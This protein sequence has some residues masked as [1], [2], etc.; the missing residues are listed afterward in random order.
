MDPHARRVGLGRLEIVYSGQDFIAE[1][2]LAE[3]KHQSRDCSRTTG[4]LSFRFG[5]HVAPAS[6][7]VEVDRFMVGPDAVSVRDR[8]LPHS[9]RWDGPSLEVAVESTPGY[10]RSPLVANA[11]R[12]V[13][14]SFDDA[15]ARLGKRFYYTVFDQAVQLAQVPLG[16]SWVHS[17]AVTN[18]DR[19]VL[20]M[21]WGGVG[22]TAALLK[23]LGTGSWRFLSDDLS[24]LDE[25]GTVHHTPQ[26]VQVF[27]AN[28]AGQEAL[29]SALLAG[30]SRADLF[31]WEARRR[32]LGA[33][34]VRRRVHGEEL[35]GNG[36]AAVSGRVT[37][38]VQLRRTNAS[39]F[40][41]EVS[42]PHDLAWIATSVLQVELEPLGLWLAAIHGAGPTKQWPTADEM[43][44]ETA[45]VIE[46]GLSEAG[47]RCLVLGVP[48]RCGPD[49]L[50]RFIEDEVLVR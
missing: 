42:T 14:Q 6:G 36:E 33:R 15:A 49:E 9:L 25:S 28:V 47:A 22:K 41:L 45:S 34:S 31:H 1:A 37:D 46:A 11:V 19:T 4:S 32:L 16:Q 30:R 40:T 23:M 39:H 18:G 2:A 10:W 29:R 5:T 13:D 48:R 21:A 3:L 26:R 35:F 27:A 43:I 7:A 24:L 17:S 8:F 50:L 38:A 12:L 44:R 20:F